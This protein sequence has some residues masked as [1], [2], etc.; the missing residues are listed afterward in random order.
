MTPQTVTTTPGQDAELRSAVSRLRSRAS[1]LRERASDL[2]PLVAEAYRRR[3]AELDLAAFVG[4]RW[5]EG[6]A[7]PGVAA[8]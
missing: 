7:G 4:D 2:H 5:A 8:A 3:A 1:S 6:P